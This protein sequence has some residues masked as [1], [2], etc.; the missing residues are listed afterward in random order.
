M[1]RTSKLKMALIAS[2]FAITLVS[3][4]KSDFGT[5]TG[6]Q[7]PNS[8]PQRTDF[9][10]KAVNGFSH[11]IMLNIDGEDYYLAG[12]PDGPD[13]ATDIPGHYWQQTG[14]N[15]LIGKHFN[16]GP[17]GKAQWWSSTA[18]DGALLYLVNAQIDRWNGEIA[19]QK[20]TAGFVHYHE[21]VRVSD[22]SL[23]PNKVLWLQHVAVRHF[24]LDGGPHPELAH[25]VRPGLD[26]NFIP[27]GMMPYQP[28]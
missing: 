24:Y 20:A 21:L 19:K 2:A 11:G 25:F 8:E 23:H 5:D 7:A 14:E 13:G 18:P 3:C 28:E 1:L 9:S 27:N 4:Q 15:T 12:A 6:S 17:F 26:T 10:Q 16:T 22:G